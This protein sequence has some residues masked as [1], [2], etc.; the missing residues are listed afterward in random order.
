MQDLPPFF[1]A[2]VFAPEKMGA[3]GPPNSSFRWTEALP[4]SVNVR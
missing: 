4:T 1:F 3:K 2:D